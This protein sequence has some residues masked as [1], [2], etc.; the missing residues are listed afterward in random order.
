MSPVLS[1]VLDESTRRQWLRQVQRLR[2]EIFALR[3]ALYE[4]ER[5]DRKNT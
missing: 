1:P 2:Q 4:R 5:I 3:T